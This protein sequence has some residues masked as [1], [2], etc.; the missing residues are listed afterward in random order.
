[1][2]FATLA[3]EVLHEVERSLALMRPFG[4]GDY[5]NGCTLSRYER[6]LAMLAPDVP[7]AAA[8]LEA[9]RAADPVGRTRTIGDPVFRSAVHKLLGHHRLHL[10]QPD[11]AECASL[12]RQAA[13]HLA[14]PGCSPLAVGVPAPRRLGTAAH[15]GW[16]WQEERE[17][18]AFARHFRALLHERVPHLTPATPDA[19]LLDNLVRGMAL[20]DT[21]LPDLARSALSHVQVVV[22]ADVPAR[23]PLMPGEEPAFTS[24][25]NPFILGTIFL[26]PNVLQTPWSVAEYLLHEGL[27]QKFMDLEHTHSMLRKG[28]SVEESPVISPPWHRVQLSGASQW[29][30]N[31]SISVTH[32]YTA[33]ALFFA[34]ARERAVELQPRFGPV[35]IPE[36]ELSLRQSFDRATYLGEK[37]MGA[38]DELGLAGQRFLD[39]LNGLL[40]TFDPAP[41]PGGAY[42]HL[43]LDLY[44]REAREFA[45]RLAHLSPADLERPVA[46]V[47]GASEAITVPALI[48]HLEAVETAR[49]REVMAALGRTVPGGFDAPPASAPLAER[50]A[51]VAARFRGV[52]QRVSNV[53]REVPWVEYQAAR[54]VGASRPDE[55]VRELLGYSD[56]C[57][58]RLLKHI[59]A[60]HHAVA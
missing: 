10:P 51:D 34:R 39:W 12:L 59:T 44:D 41:P 37:L 45:T 23:R 55:A 9:L 5:I 2:A 13:T 8:V 58:G 15:H 50:P 53:L 7:E 4:D 29:H 3:P 48:A 27:H 46:P 26:A 28:Y 57:L 14:T 30:V 40:R 6:Q 60:S 42:V 18:D 56:R 52:R 11:A 47:P 24:L 31:R 35:N 33:L 36:L 20:L 17:E 43:L 25:T 16:I 54:E 19:R 32:V 49:A 22:M 1:M 38:R 21:L